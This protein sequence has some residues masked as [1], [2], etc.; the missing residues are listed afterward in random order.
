[1]EMAWT[2]A[3]GVMQRVE[4]FMKDLY[5]K[6]SSSVDCSIPEGNFPRITYDEAMSRHGVDKPDI[7]FHDLV[8]SNVRYI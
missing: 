8:S 1:M 5:Q 2:D 6:L 3:E 4:Q 7:R